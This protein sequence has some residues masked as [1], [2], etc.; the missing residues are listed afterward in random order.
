[1]YA[2]RPT[3]DAGPTSAQ[4]SYSSIASDAPGTPMDSS[5]I[6]SPRDSIHGDSDT[7]SLGL[8][9]RELMDDDAGADGYISDSESDSLGWSSDVSS[10]GT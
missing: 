8:P 4:V 6:I 1:M 3:A 7:G 10:R 5:S 9:G 2:E